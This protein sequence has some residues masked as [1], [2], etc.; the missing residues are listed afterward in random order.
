MRNFYKFLVMLGFL[1]SG[2]SHYLIAQVGINTDNST[3]DP[4]AGLDVKFNNKGFLPPR[5][6]LTAINAALPVTSPAS[7]LLV[8]NIAVAGTPPNNVIPGYYIWNGTR[9]IPVAAPQGTTVGDMQY[10]NGTQWVNIPVGTNGQVLTLINGIPTW[11]QSTSLCGMGMTI[12]HV[13]GTVAPVSK[14]V[15]YGTVTNIP[16]EP[17]KCWITSNL[18]SDHQATAVNDATEASAGWYWQFNRKQGYKHDGTVRTPNTTWIT[19]INETSD[20]ITANDPCNVELGTTWRLPTFTEWYNVNFAGGWT[21]WTGP[22]SSGLK[23]HAAGY[24]GD[25]DGS[26][27]NRGSRGMYWGSTQ[28]VDTEGW[29][30]TFE[31]IYSTQGNGNKV[32]G[33]T[34]RC[35]RDY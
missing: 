10:W 30:M 26:L 15:T 13:A 21:S 14:S 22:W 16:G 8:Y 3:P 31:S 29:Y 17:T 32:L 20:W 4:S 23:L 12:N 7:G 18:G 27:N 9:W 2:P 28:Y 6:A 33:F 25:Y 19:S 1:L 11:R 24:L 5:V 34:V 35:V